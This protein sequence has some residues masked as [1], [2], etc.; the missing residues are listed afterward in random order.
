MPRAEG[1]SLRVDRAAG[2]GPEAPTGPGRGVDGDVE[3]AGGAAAAVSTGNAGAAAVVVEHVG[4]AGEPSG[5]T[6]A[7]SG[8]PA[9]AARAASGVSPV[10]SSNLME[11]GKD[12]V[13]GGSARSASS[14]V[15]NE[16]VNATDARGSDQELAE[17]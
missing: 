14:Q 13:D 7:G 1:A 12:E 5:V 11:K 4:Q 10:D 9:A 8:E 17:Y 16:P 2:T 3:A 15:I 6:A